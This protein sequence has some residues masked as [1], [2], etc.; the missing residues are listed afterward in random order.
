MLDLKQNAGQAHSWSTATHRC[1]I[2]TVVEMS[3]N[4][5]SGSSSTKAKDRSKV[6][7]YDMNFRQAIKVV[8]RQKIKS[9]YK[10]E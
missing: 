3:N 5:Q 7:N 1:G 8:S 2:Q 4:R 6:R 10:P 9:G